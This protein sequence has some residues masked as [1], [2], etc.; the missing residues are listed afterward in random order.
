MAICREKRGGRVYLAEY[1]NVWV[2]GKVKH[3][4]VRYLGREGPDGKPLRQPRHVLDSVDI[5]GTKRYGDVAVMWTLAEHLQFP[6]IIDKITH[7]D[8]AVSTGKVLSMWAVNRALAPESATGLQHWAGRTALGELAG[9]A[10]DK[11]NKDRLFRALDDV[12]LSDD[13]GEDLYDH[14]LSIEKM[15]FKQNRTSDS[16]ALAFDLT[17]TYFYGTSCPIAR[18]GYNRDKK[19]GRLQIVI[20]LAVSRK[21]KLPLFHRVYPGDTHDGSTA[22]QFLSTAR[23]FGIQHGTIIWDRALTTE[24]TLKLSQTNGYNLIAGLPATRN[25]VVD[26]LKKAGNI[27]KMDHFIQKN[28]HGSLYA[29]SVNADVFDMPQSVVV[30]LN[31]DMREGERG[32]RYETLLDIKERLEELSAKKANLSEGKL[33]KASRKIVGPYSDF[34]KPRIKREGVRPR[35]EINI[36]KRMVRSQELTEGRYAILHT[37]PTLSPR[38]V[39]EEYHGKDFIEKAFRSLKQDVEIR[40]VRHRMPSRIRAYTLVCVMGYYLRARL[41]AMLRDARPDESFDD[42]IEELADVQRTTLTYGRSSSVRYLNMPQ[43]KKATLKAMGLAS[44]F[45]QVS[46]MSEPQ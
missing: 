8:S 35:I 14:S 44:M 27:E 34:I 26:A 40:P 6:E 41:A 29:K 21:D 42:F 23:G 32:E 30:C 18:K 39:V 25:D 38:Q 36:Q 19:L 11:M 24:D 43:R 45:R 20:A 13:S 7:S 28:G 12:C 17:S 10:H 1:K 3:K 22:V 46:A 5:S 31:T 15:I 2:D 16:D 4:F 9:I 33:R 37:D